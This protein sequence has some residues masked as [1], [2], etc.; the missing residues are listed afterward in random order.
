LQDR[1]LAGELDAAIYALPDLTA[2][3]KLNRLTLYREPFVIVVKT[4]HRLARRGTVRAQ[5]LSGEPYL[6]RA[7]CEY[8][9]AAEEI[10]A[11]RGANRSTVYCSDRDDWI[12]SM[13]AAGLGYGFMPASGAVYPGVIALRLI[14]PE[15]ARE[16]ALVTVRGRAETAGVGALLREAMRARWTSAPAALPEVETAAT[17]QIETAPR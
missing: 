15:I 2:D 1:L 11:R 6:S 12:L 9:A 5:D 3:E 7:H 16:I 4:A 13:A 14:E 8:D 10:F 17:V